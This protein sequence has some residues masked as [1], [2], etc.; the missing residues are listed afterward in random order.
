MQ[1]TV[2]DDYQDAFRSLEC[3]AKL[4]DHDVKVCHAPA[5]TE[6][7]LIDMLRDDEAVILTQQRTLMPRGLIENL[8]KLKMISQTGRNTAHIDL[9]ACKE[10]GIVVC[11]GGGGGGHATAQPA[12]GPVF[13][14]A[15]P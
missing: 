13:F 14:A 4:K 11:A 6:A 1:I 2:I 7:D 9:V 10:R 15:R 8:P 3:F 12:R 5:E